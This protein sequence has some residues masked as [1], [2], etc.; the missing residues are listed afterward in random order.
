[1]SGVAKTDFDGKGNLTQV[2]HVVHNGTV[3][4]EDWRP[5]IGS[6]SI[7]PDCTGWM[8]FTPQPADPADAGPELKLYIVVLKSGNEIRTVVSGSPTTPP[9]TSNITSFGVRLTSAEL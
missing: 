4:V 1:V 9:F 6:Y 3:P 7:N 8:T 5:A 2:D